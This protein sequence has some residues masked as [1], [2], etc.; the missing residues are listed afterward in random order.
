MLT[1]ITEKI[2]DFMGQKHSVLEVEQML[3]KLSEWLHPHHY[4]I[5]SLKHLLVQSYG[6]VQGYEHCQL[7][8]H[9]LNRKL[10]LCEELHD[11]CQKIDPHT[12][13][14][15]LY[16]AVILYE[17][18]SVLMEFLK[19][20]NLSQ[21][22]NDKCTMLT[23]AHTKLSKALQILKKEQDNESGRKLTDKILKVLQDL[24]IISQSASTHS[25]K[26]V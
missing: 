25:D 10:E 26:Q 2:D 6:N 9:I 11:I 3:V 22:P 4:H 17:S 1:Q 15:S 7:E 19:R 18:A 5:F 16:V 20:S 8:D 13:R 24:E 12:I 14:L 21:T 23:T